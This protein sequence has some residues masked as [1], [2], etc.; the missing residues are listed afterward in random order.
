M[1]QGTLLNQLLVTWI[2][3]V[4]L[5]KCNSW[6]LLKEVVRPCA[7]CSSLSSE[8]KPAYEYE[9]AIVFA[10]ATFTECVTIT[11]CLFTKCLPSCS[12]MH[13]GQWSTAVVKLFWKFIWLLLQ[14]HNFCW[15]LLQLHDHLYLLLH[16][17]HSKKFYL[18]RTTPNKLTNAGIA[19]PSNFQFWCHCAAI[20]EI[21][22]VCHS[23]PVPAWPTPLL[24]G[25][26][27]GQFTN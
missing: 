13:G 21:Q 10:L 27:V 2:A 20:E 15:V 16:D 3:S 14:E 25:Q 19:A 22:H 12:T 17:L 1:N 6:V 5:F 26:N 18:T 23:V 8:S 11:S 24:I 9:G 4:D 7:Q